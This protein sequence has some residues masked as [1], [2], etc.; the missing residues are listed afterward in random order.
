MAGSQEIV[1]VM[2]SIIIP[3]LNEEDYL[4]LLLESIKN[5]KFEE[6]YEIIVADNNSK[7]RTVEIAENYGCKVVSGG[8]PAKGRNEG[9]KA[10][11]GD[12]FLFLDADLVLPE[13]FLAKFLKEFRENDLDIASSDL[14]FLT[15]KKIYKIGA[16]LCSF[17]F[18]RAQRFL[19]CITECIL[20]KK[21]FHQE[22]EFDEDVRLLE[23]FVYVR[24]IA[25]KGK[26]GHLSS[27]KFY[28]STRRFE[29]DGKFK[30]LFKYLLANIYMVLLG[31]IKSDI[32][33]YKFNHRSQK[34]K[35]EI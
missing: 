23:D 26:F 28:T 14:D 25:K 22:G 11:Q 29:K 20:V 27:I 10:A 15:D 4:P 7:D 12:L 5:Q 1:L 19:P 16:K 33:N 6:E 17:Y 2:L 9:V 18:K 24:K 32:F 13:G 8:L 21:Y 35:K 34:T 3:T 30:T 31:P